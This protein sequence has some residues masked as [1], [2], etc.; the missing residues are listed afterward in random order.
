[1][2]TNFSK[3]TIT[4]EKATALLGKQGIVI[5]PE[6]MEAVINFL[7]LLAE[8]FVNEIATDEKS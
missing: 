2:E 6:E 4:P 7:Y 3:R 5:K 1:M 8:I